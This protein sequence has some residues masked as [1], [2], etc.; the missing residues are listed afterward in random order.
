MLSADQM[1]SESTFG[2]LSP[3]ILQRDVS[4]SRYIENTGEGSIKGGMS[5]R[6][7]LKK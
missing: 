3:F 5:C 4:A 2:N 6:I 7:V 1:K